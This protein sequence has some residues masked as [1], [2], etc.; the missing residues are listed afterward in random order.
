MLGW[1]SPRGARPAGDV[2]DWGGA[3][4]D[5]SAGAP[6]LGLPPAGSPDALLSGA[7][8]GAAWL[9]GPPAAQARRAEKW[10]AMLRAWPA[11]GDAAAA[12]KVK[13]RARKGV[14]PALR[15]H[16][17]LQLATGGAGGGAARAHFDALLAGAAGDA[18][19]DAGPD[20]AP[21]G[22]GGGA[23]ALDPVLRAALLAHEGAGGAGAAAAIFSASA[24]SSGGGGGSFTA[25][26]RAPVAPDVLAAVARDIART[27]PR[28]P[29][30]SATRAEAGDGAC[31]SSTASAGQAALAR[32][33]VAY[34]RGDPRV[35]YCQGL[36]F[37][38]ALL[39]L[40]ATGTLSVP[41]LADAAQEEGAREG[42]GAD[43][44]PAPS[45][46][47]LAAFVTP[48]AEA[49]AF[50]M[51]WA[52]MAPARGDAGAAAGGGGGGGIVG[53]GGG[54][55]AASGGAAAAGGSGGSEGARHLSPPPPSMAVLFL[56]GLPRL[57]ALLHV[58]SGLLNARLPALAA[59]FSAHGVHASMWA[60]QWLMTVFSYSLPLP[61]VARIWDAFLAEGWKVPLRVALAL[62]R[63]NERALLAAARDAGFE[64]LLL[65]LQRVPALPP[66]TTP[67]ALL[68]AA[69]AIPRFSWRACAN[70][71][72]EEAWL[73]ETGREADAGGARAGSFWRAMPP[74]DLE[75]LRARAAP[76][77][78]PPGSDEE[79]DGPA[80][81]A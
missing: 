26:A 6:P 36:N 11:R 30:F 75:R 63:A 12:L 74:A 79:G 41:L 72:A 39:L 52:V 5:A 37:I 20:G 9:A 61:A 64:G 73:R 51:L 29:L 35:G 44:P 67:D 70:L 38:A 13:A 4:P 24:A 2:A 43:A 60:T 68:A 16:A 33:L 34:A 50:A 14:P 22:G 15:A 65:R 18:D 57:T 66:A 81:D 40:A 78:P 25:A 21:D 55:A 7:A 56:P 62:L 48:A 71:L 77:P 69:F 31:G 47:E 58:L 27:F 23:R 32:V 8:G 19:A 59:A 53:G 45:A 46:R 10:A 49:A 1:L 76:P 54:A 80:G 28:H 17:W 42:G 3:A